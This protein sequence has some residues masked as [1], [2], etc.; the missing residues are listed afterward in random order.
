MLKILVIGG[1]V[2]GRSIAWHLQ[3]E[4]IQVVIVDPACA[5]SAASWGN[6]GHI[7]TEQ[8]VPLASRAMVRSLPRRLFVRGG[9]L[10]LP[11]R[12]IATWLPFALRLLRSTQP[13]RFAAGEAALGSLLAAAMPAWRRLVAGLGAPDL[14][15]EQGHLVAWENAGSAV[16]GRAAWQAANT[17]TARVG[18]ADASDH[19][20]LSALSPNVVDAIR[21]S[22]SG[23]VS[24]L[25][26][27]AAAFDH[28]LIAAGVRIERGTATI[29]RRG[30]GVH[31][32]GFDADRII[33][34]AGIG[35]RALMA[36]AGDAVPL[37]AERG[38]H[39]RAAADHWPADLPP[40][41][42]E[43]RS[44]IVTRY[45]D[46]VQVA[47][48][49]EFG[50]ADAPPDPRKWD[51][52]ESHVAALGMPI[53]GPFRRW[54]GARPTLPDYLPA[55]G[56]SRRAAN[57]Y[58]AFGHQHLGLTLAPVTGE[59]MAAMVLGEAP[60]IDCTPFDIARF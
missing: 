15:R 50:R 48:F 46:S 42:F 29:E 19:T 28:A 21:F 44:I 3:R 45:V 14:L 9:P 22:G 35:S 47:G 23:Q 17:G 38:Y 59:L 6:A 12:M 41:V 8:V 39:I 31:V 18:E 36:A 33:V 49:V 30:A 7:A 43:D 58:Y 40:V 37:I 4:G 52:L 56:R 57:L 16:K 32:A 24:D 51:R 26:A 53:A 54:I 10:D 1:G 25:D 5:G 11:P 13:R 27:L 34:A 2:V 20:A 60:A 55:I